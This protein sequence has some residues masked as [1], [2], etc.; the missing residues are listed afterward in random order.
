MAV[1]GGTSGARGVGRVL[2]AGGRRGIPFRCETL[3]IREACSEWKRRC[4]SRGPLL[5]YADYAR[6]SPLAD[7]PCHPSKAAERDGENSWR[8]GAPGIAEFRQGCGGPLRR[9]GRRRVAQA[10]RAH[11]VSSPEASRQLSSRDAEAR[12]PKSKRAIADSRAPRH[13]L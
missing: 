11:R 7:A 10:R 3:I 13:G 12:W 9:T 5:R 2:G 8:A 6:A 1:V 4:L